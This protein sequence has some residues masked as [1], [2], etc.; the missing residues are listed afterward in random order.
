MKRYL[1]LYAFLIMALSLMAHEDRAFRITETDMVSFPGGKCMMYRL[2]L[3]DKDLQH[4]PFSV[5]RPEQFLS[6][7]SI[8]RRKRQGLSVD[9]TD[10]PIAPAYLDSVSRTGIEIVGQSKWNNTLLVKIHKEKELNKLNS[11]SFI[12]RKLKVFSSPDS[13]T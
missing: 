4:T 10:L 7:R 13:I 5:S 12:T 11:L 6:A 3:R 8:E 9:V 2:Y 1:M